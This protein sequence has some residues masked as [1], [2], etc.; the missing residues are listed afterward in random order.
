MRIALESE[1]RSRYVLRPTTGGQIPEHSANGPRYYK[2]TTNDKWEDKNE[3]K[4]CNKGSCEKTE[5]ESQI[6]DQTNDI[7]EIK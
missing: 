2:F 1:I 4:G 6:S 7:G 3:M 5:V